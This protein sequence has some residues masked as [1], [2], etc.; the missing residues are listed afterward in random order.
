MDSIL[1]VN[2]SST[3]SQ[4]MSNL[5]IPTLASR[6]NDF[7]TKFVGILSC[8]RRH[9]DIIDCRASLAQYRLYKEDV[10]ELQAKLDENVNREKTKKLMVVKEWL[11][12]GEQSQLD[13]E[14]FCKIRRECATTARWITQHDIMK[15]WIHSDIPNS[16]VVWMYGIPG[17]GM[18]HDWGYSATLTSS[19]QNHTSIRYH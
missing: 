8:L 15:H 3:P 5:L 9:K 1:Q 4:T 13:H 18:Y 2:V 10:T 16:S 12:V 14:S 19:R 11:A 6:W 17:A 7:H